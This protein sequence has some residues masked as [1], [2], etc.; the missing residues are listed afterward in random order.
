MLRKAILV[1]A[2]ALLPATGSPAWADE[3]TDQL[4][5]ARKA[6][7]SGELRTAIQALQFAVAKIQEKI[8]ASLSQLLPKPL[9]GWTADEPET[10]SG[11]IAA[12]IAGTTLSRRY[13]RNDGAEVDVSITA[14]S[15]LLP[16]M[17]MMLSSPMLLQSDPNTKLYT[18]DGQRGLIEH[19][20][21]SDRW[22]I[23]LMVGNKILV[24]VAAS[25]VKSADPA[26]AYLKAIDLEAL[27][28]AFSG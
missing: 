14:D 25:A 28:K 8:N 1:A 11:G 23:K 6:Y 17:T 22:E 20:K 10:Q 21:D 5:G 4:D 24:Q 15:P 13:H 3:V 19:D 18:Y 16:M 9:P 2:I 12:M 7:Q 26:K 27:Q